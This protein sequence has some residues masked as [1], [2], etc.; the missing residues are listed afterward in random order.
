MLSYR[1]AYH[2]GNFAD[3]CKHVALTILLQALARKQRPF[4]YVDTHA[5]AGRYDLRSAMAQQHREYES[6]IARLWGEDDDAPESVL[7]YLAIVRAVNRR[8]AAPRTHTGF[9]AV[10]RW[11]P[12]SPRVARQLLRDGDRMVLA[13]MHKAEIAEIAREFAGDR[14]VQLVRGD[15]YQLLRS[16]LPPHE[17]RGLV[18][19][20]PAYEQRD[21]IDSIIAALKEGLRRWASGVYAIWYPIMPKIP[22][23]T[24]ERRVADCGAEKVLSA[25]LCVLPNDNPLGVNGSG[26]IIINPPYRV[27]E[28][29]ETSF[30][31]LWRR[32]A[33]HGQGR[34]TVRWLRQT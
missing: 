22:V 34:H 33:Q 14:K 3:V 11:Y 13:E 18:L 10:P 16:T 17:R 6:G 5:G 9:K 25:E 7:A 23:N 1:H 32:L 24:L 19:I 4:L 29:L 27:D 28:E 12:G 2:A 20:D 21:T 26:V 30:A 15:G 31:W 8:A